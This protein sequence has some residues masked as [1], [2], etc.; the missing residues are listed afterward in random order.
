MQYERG[1]Y[2]VCPAGTSD[3]DIAYS[4]G[5]S[6]YMAG[7]EDPVDINMFVMMSKSPFEPA[8]IE[9]VELVDPQDIGSN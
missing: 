8:T 6:F 9:P 3:F 7:S 4:D 1:Y 2:V 5:E